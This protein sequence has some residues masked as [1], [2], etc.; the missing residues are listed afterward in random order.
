MGPTVP[1]P[2]IDLNPISA[3]TTPTSVAFSWMAPVDD[4]GSPITGYEILWDQG[5]GD[6]VKLVAS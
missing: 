6:W 5:N 3:S 2:P 4:G 1:G